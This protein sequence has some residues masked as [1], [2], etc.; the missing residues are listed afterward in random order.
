MGFVLKFEPG[1]IWYTWNSQVLETK[2]RPFIN[3]KLQR[4]MEPEH[5]RRNGYN[6]YICIIPAFFPS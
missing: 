5:Q 6:R 3:N 4:S 1:Y 2:W